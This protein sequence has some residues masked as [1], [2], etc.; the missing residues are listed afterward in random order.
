MNPEPIL[1]AC[2]GIG[3]AGFPEDIRPRQIDL[4]EMDYFKAKVDAG[5]DYIVTNCSSIIATFSISGMLCA[6]G[7]RIP[8]SP[9]HADYLH[10]RAETHR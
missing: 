4:V 3:V 7:V 5:A 6:R 1:T 8:L 2:F 10:Q 9:N